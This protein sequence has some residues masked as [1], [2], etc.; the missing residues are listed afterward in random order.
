MNARLFKAWTVGQTSCSLCD[1]W[2]DPQGERAAMHQHPEPQSGDIRRQWMASGLA[3]AQWSVVT[4]I[5]S[6]WEMY[7]NGFI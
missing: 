3:Y 7:R 5:G 2:Y 1:E 4:Q 6:V